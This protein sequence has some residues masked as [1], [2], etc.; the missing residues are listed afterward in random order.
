MQLSETS[1]RSVKR[2]LDGN[3]FK[4]AAQFTVRDL[5]KYTIYRELN[6]LAKLYLFCPEHIGFAMIARE[7]AIPSDMSS[8]SWDEDKDELFDKEWAL[9]KKKPK[10]HS[11]DPT[12]IVHH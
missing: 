2:F 4:Y 8:F 1:S 5:M 6:E 12:G 7:A 11:H 9:V 3:S 10:I